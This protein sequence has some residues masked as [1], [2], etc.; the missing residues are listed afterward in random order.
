MIYAFDASRR[1]TQLKNKTKQ[2]KANKQKTVSRESRLAYIL[3]GY[4]FSPGIRSKKVDSV[5]P[6]SNTLQHF[7][8]AYNLCIYFFFSQDANPR[9]FQGLVT[10]QNKFKIANIFFFVMAKVPTT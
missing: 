9:S 4:Y 8:C 2:K 5:S 3:V 7:V 1:Q 10:C 6:S